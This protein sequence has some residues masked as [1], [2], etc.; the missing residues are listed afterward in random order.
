[1]YSKRAFVHWNV[2][3]GMEEASF[4]N[5]VVTHCSLVDIGAQG[6]FSEARED[7]VT[8]EDDYQEVSTDS[9]DAEEESEY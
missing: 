5:Q 4:L 1:M 9:A 3:K 7:L 8:L 6:E 2:S